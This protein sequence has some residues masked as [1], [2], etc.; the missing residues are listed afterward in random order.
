[1]TRPFRHFLVFYALALSVIAA[2]GLRRSSGED[3]WSMRLWPAISYALLA[4]GF[5]FSRD[6]QKALGKVWLAILSV[7]LFLVVIPTRYF[8]EDSVIFALLLACYL[9]PTVMLIRRLGPSGGSAKGQARCIALSASLLIGAAIVASSLFQWITYR[10]EGSTSGAPGWA[11]LAWKAQWVTSFASVGKSAISAASIPW[12][13]PI[14]G[15]VGYVFYLLGLLAT[16]ALTALVLK[17]RFSMERMRASAMMAPLTAV[18]SWVS[19]WLVTDIFW[20]WHFDLSEIPWVAALAF[21]CW[22]GALVFGAVLL[23]P[24]A[25]GD[26]APWR[27]R[28]VLIFQL[29]LVAFNFAPLRGYFTDSATPFPGL[30]LLILGM[31]IESWV[32]MDLLA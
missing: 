28:A 25:R 7:L 12:L 17:S 32:C 10:A 18:I 31:L 9:A 14:F 19:L 20:G 30:G 15:P 21:A 29:P 1:M 13:Q 16:L 8:W 27:L 11:V 3:P 24:V 26:L 5:W 6:V 23:L 4:I 22:L 2:G